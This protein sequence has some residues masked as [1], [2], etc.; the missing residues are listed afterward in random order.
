M[1]VRHVFNG[2]ILRGLAE[3]RRL[4]PI[5]VA[6]YLQ[7]YRNPF[8]SVTSLATEAGLGRERLRRAAHRLI[9]YGWL[10]EVPS[11]S[12]YNGF[13]LRWWLPP[14]QERMVA[15]RIEAM[16]RN[17]RFVGE[18]LMKAL[19]DL[20]IHDSQCDDN[21]RPPWMVS[22]IG[23]GRLE[24]DRWYFVAEIVFEFQGSQ[25][26]GIGGP[27]AP[28]EASLA[29]QVEN[30]YLKAGICARE[31]IR[32]I[33]VYPHEL[34]FA[35]LSQKLRGIIPLMPVPEDSLLVQTLSRMCRSY[36]NYVARKAKNAEEVQGTGDDSH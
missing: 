5:D 9:Q 33:E 2:A 3:D 17:T 15:A 24:F 31:G 11:N 21:A 27:Y 1:T 7:F 32:V 25:H 29:R 34:S 28:N 16:R 4:E 6:A 8:L 20:M 22:G 23:G 30:D 36:V 13:A 26:T 12:R 35:S 19:L 10:Y 14:D 18:W